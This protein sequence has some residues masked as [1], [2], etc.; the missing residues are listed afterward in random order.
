MNAEEYAALPV[1]PDKGTGEMA[2]AQTRQIMEM[3]RK[4]PVV[5]RLLAAI[6]LSNKK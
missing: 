5:S 6:R 2:H 4:H 1:K 3:R